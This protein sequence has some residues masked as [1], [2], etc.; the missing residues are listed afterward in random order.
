MF[1]TKNISSIE[2]NNDNDHLFD[3]YGKKRI[4]CFLQKN[5]TIQERYR[6]VSY[7]F[8][9]NEE[10]AKRMY[11]YSSKHL[12]SYSTPILAFANQTLPISCY[13]LHIDDTTE[14]LLET[15]YESNKLTTSGGGI[16]IYMNIRPKDEKSTGVL[17]HIKTYDS[18]I[19][20]YK[21]GKIRR[22][23]CAIYLDI[24][25]PEIETFLNIRKPTGDSDIRC[26][27]IHHAINISDK[28]M[29][30]IKECENNKNYDDTWELISP[31]NNDVIKKVSAK[32]LWMNILETRVKT[33]EPYICFIDTC[34]EKRHDF[35]KKH[36]LKIYQSNLC[37]EIILPTYKNR[38]AICCLSS[39]NL[40]KWDEI[41]QNKNIIE[42]LCE[43]LD[44]VLTFFIGEVKNNNKYSRLQKTLTSCEE[45]RNIGIGVMGFHSYILSK[46][47]SM[48]SNE[49]KKINIEI[50]Q[51]IKN[52]IDKSN[53]RLGKER[54]VPKV[55]ENTGRRFSCTTAIAPT[56]T[57]SIIMGNTSPSCDPISGNTF[58]QN[59]SIGSSLFVNKYIKQL[60]KEKKLDQ[61][62]IIQRIV[63]NNGSIQNMSEF[64]KE[65][66]EI[67]KTSFEIDQNVLLELAKDRS[68]FIDQAQSL[69]LFIKHNIDAKTLHK[70]HMKAWEYKLKTLYYLRSTRIV[71][72]IECESC[73]S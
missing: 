59:T 10:H 49:T 27:N 40:E 2:I 26:H 5:E 47:L 13:C 42:D 15:Q 21:Q 45:E 18:S 41:R 34:N 50:F 68:I 33:G 19:M 38:T 12:I 48:E 60:L 72:P 55:C 65:E 24:S 9:S 70:I 39:L 64:N 63:D 29:K 56:A 35:L 31:Y 30:I 3:E 73:Q 46:K 37:T 53:V 58:R 22:G 8:A 52:E 16:S 14:S 54:G 66:K 69:N 7:F 17:P 4:E 20:A 36:D 28:F 1:N 44:N 57:S 11:E 32:Q 23:A 62:K 67:F 6:Y 51:H 25:H 61:K 43:F 71:N